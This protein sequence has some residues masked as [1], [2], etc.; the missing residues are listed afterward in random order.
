MDLG[1]GADWPE[2]NEAGVEHHPKA[3]IIDGIGK[4]TEGDS[5]GW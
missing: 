4:R 2:G 5:Q 1:G 3:F